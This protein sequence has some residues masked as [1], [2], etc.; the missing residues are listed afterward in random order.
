M[1]SLVEGLVLYPE[2]HLMKSTSAV[3]ILA[4]ALSLGVFAASCKKNE[5]PAGPG[6][7]ADIVNTNPNTTILKAAVA[8]AGLG[9]A[10]SGG[11]LTAFAPDDAA[12]A[13]SGISLAAVNSLPVSTLDSILKYH[14]LGSSVSSSAVP[15]SDAV[16]TLLGTS[17][18]ASKNANG[19]FV[20]GIGVK[21]AD[22]AASNGVIHIIS[23]VLI[24]PTKTIAGVATTDTN[25][26]LLVAAVAKA[27][28]VPAISGP[29]K[30]TVFAPT[31]AAFRAAGFSTVADINAASTDL[32][33]TVVKY[34][35]ITTNVFASDLTDGLTAASLQGGNLTVN[36][37][38]ARV[39]V[40]SSSNP[41]SKITAADIVCTNGVIHVIDRVLLP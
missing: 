30:F 8:R 20:N 15:A 35:V 17:L 2:T 39:K 7:I 32:I 24:P 33:T 12:F 3:K 41:S 14:V 28:L 16:T 11:S 13:A 36:L 29:G 34:H 6:T 5:T 23:K 19:V 26:T 9:T 31:N 18:F 1:I 27:G 40:S 10:L 4:L 37:S 21:T 38:P 25:F 22:V